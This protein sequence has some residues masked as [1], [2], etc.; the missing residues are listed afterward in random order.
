MAI[1]EAEIMAANKVDV[2]VVGIN[3]WS[4]SSQPCHAEVQIR[5]GKVSVDD[6]CEAIKPIKRIK[7]S[8]GNNILHVSPCEFIIDNR[9][10]TSQP[11]GVVGAHLQ[12]EACIITADPDHISN[13]V[14]ACKL[15]GLKTLSIV[16]QILA[17]AETLL[18]QEELE[19]G[20]LHID[21]GAGPAK[22]TAF[23]GNTLLSYSKSYISGNKLTEDIAVG[24]RI[25]MISAE[26]IK[27]KHGCCLARMVNGVEMIEIASH[28]TGGARL[29][30]RGILASISEA[31]LEEMFI[32][33]AQEFQ[34]YIQNNTL[35]RV[36]ITGGGS[37]L[38]GVLELA[39][40]VFSMPVRIG[41]QQ[42]N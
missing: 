22:V 42:I 5:N 10:K 30:P 8:V 4:V 35:A 2:A 16:P 14:R 7:L 21:M 34:G 38:N 29:I 24:L 36:V 6:I 26:D 13:L 19:H 15:A 23:G 31:R 40:Q 9:I 18:L 11:L 1:K 3:N 25:P 27:C 17:T 20:V 33:I 28:K 39:K 32:G 37:N 41:I 12:L